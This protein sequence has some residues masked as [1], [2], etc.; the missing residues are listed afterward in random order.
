[1]IQSNLE[2]IYQQ[3]TQEQDTSYASSPLKQLEERVNALVSFLK[4]D[5]GKKDIAIRVLDRI[6]KGFSLKEI[7]GQYHLSQN[8]VQTVVRECK[9]AIMVTET[10]V[11]TNTLLITTYQAKKTLDVYSGKNAR[12]TPNTPFAFEDIN[13]TDRESHVFY[14]TVFGYSP[15]CIATTIHIT[16]NRLHQI[17]QSISQKIQEHEHSHTKIEKNDWIVYF[18]Q[19]IQRRIREPHPPLE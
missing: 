14:L 4:K 12:E 15:S 5:Y 16:N 3:A 2:S 10:E 7:A 17:T 9:T 18:W 8:K 19:E 13:F 6:S 11:I 1:M